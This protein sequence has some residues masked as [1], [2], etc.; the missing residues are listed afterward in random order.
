[1]DTHSNRPTKSAGPGAVPDWAGL[2][3]VGIVALG[4][5]SQ[6]VERLMGAQSLVYRLIVRLGELRL[7]HLAW[8]GGREAKRLLMESLERGRLPQER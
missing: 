3:P 6:P 8:P 1:M 5:P 2:M 4:T 7:P